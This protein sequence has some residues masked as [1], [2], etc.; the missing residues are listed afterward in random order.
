MHCMSRFV[1]GS[2]IGFI[3]IWQISLVTLSVVPL[4]AVS[5]AIFAYATAVFVAK[6]RKSCVEAGEIAEE[7][8]FPYL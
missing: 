3:H 2:A 1:V 8:L 4:I 7:V 5:G 6:V